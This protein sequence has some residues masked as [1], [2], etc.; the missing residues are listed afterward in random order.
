M[1]LSTP[2][3]AARTHEHLLSRDH[4]VEH[5]ELVIAK[6]HRMMFSAKSERVVLER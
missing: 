2:G 3:F 6:L 5:L 1:M 4:E